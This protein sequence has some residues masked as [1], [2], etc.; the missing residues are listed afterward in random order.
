MAGVMANLL[1]AAGGGEEGA[2]GRLSRPA[3]SA[4]FGRWAAG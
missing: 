4:G 3:V 2:G 1:C